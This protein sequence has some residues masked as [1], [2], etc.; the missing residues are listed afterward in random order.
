MKNKDFETS[1]GNI[2]ED[3]GLAN[4][5]ERLA[6]ADLAVQINFLIK[7][8][9]LNQTA[10]AQLLGIDQPKVSALHKGKL[11]G[12]SLERLFHFLNV[13]GQDI[14]IQITPSARTKNKPNIKVSIPKIKQRIVG[15]SDTVVVRSAVIARKS[16]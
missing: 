8:K 10:A 12:F 9:G 3:L 14:T 15:D 4:P 2:F 11:A 5:K 1:S 13:L 16:K 6:K 7:Q